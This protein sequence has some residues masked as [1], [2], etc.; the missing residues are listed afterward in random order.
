MERYFL[1]EEDDLKIV[2]LDQC[3]AH[4]YEQAQY[5][6]DSKG[7][8]IGNLISEADWCSECDLNAFESEYC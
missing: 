8:M 1:Y 2:I 5:H 4:S 3:Y 6:F 7:W